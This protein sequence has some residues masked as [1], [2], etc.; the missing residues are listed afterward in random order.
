MLARTDLDFAIGL[1]ATG[2][3]YFGYAVN[4]DN[5]RRDA[6]ATRYARAMRRNQSML[7]LNRDY[8]KNEYLKPIW[9]LRIEVSINPLT[10]FTTHGRPIGGSGYRF[11]LSNFQDFCKL[12]YII[13]IFV[14]CISRCLR[15]VIKLKKM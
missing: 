4:P 10:H 12:F 6:N 2:G 3:G 14:G 5:D 11:C 7:V 1:R 9:Y 8:L 13:D 15:S